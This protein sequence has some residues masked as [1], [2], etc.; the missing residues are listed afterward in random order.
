VIPTS[1]GIAAASPS[2]D[3]LPAAFAYPIRK[4]QKLG[5]T[6]VSPPPALARAASH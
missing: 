4:Q 1:I 3:F 6:G 5:G 2:L